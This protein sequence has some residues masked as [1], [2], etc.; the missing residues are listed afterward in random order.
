MFTQVKTPQEIFFNPQ[1]FLVPL[2]QRPYVWNQEL[3]WQPLWEDVS[4]VAERIANTGVSTPHFL[5]AVVLQ[6]QPAELGTI[7]VRSVIDGQQ[8]LT[9]LQLFLDAV[10]AQ[11]AL[12]G[13]EDLAK[14]VQDL[15]ENPK[16]F[17]KAPEDAFKVWPTNRDRPAF[18]E[19][20]SASVPVDYSALA[21]CENRLVKAHRFFSTEVSEWLE[22]GE[23]ERRAN[24]LVLAMTNFL[25]IV[26]I[27]LLAD[28]DAQEIFET[29]NARGTPLTAAD[30]IKN[31][32]FQRLEVSPE[33]AERAYHHYWQ[34]FETPFWETEI[35]SGRIRYTRSSLF[36][37]HWLVAQTR[38]EITAREVFSKFKL[39]V[40]D[41]VE[42]VDALLPRL[43]RA[44]LKFQEV[45]EGATQS[46]GALSRVE[47]FVYRT[48]TLDSEVVKPLLIWLLDPEQEPIESEQLNKALAAV[49]SWL[50]R[51]A[52][53]KATTKNYNQFLLE[54]LIEIG[55]NERQRVG[56]VTEEFLCKQTSSS[57]Y[58]PGDAEVRAELTTQPVYR[59]LVR[60][61]LRMILEALEDKRRGF[62]STVGGSN[63]GELRSE[64][65]YLDRARDASRVASKLAGCRV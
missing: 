25:Q 60:A 53:V 11:L 40:T 21:Q 29:L 65:R 17:R 37:S 27:D 10:H 19:V 52:I 34:I 5:G 32:V 24:A 18:N 61:R 28:E 58:W 1:R 15:V 30:L 46:T 50:V 63:D 39:F 6:Q 49:E 13:F 26:V 22:R 45:T 43:N 12:R 42:S 48:S 2:F 36:L 4:R 44:A 35:A 57:T 51:R 56:D 8:R 3:Q 55:K 20:M 7:G 64:K 54:L 33:E 38:Q 23:A 47:L 31:F 9:T 41:S 62:D 14:Q 16:H 59:R